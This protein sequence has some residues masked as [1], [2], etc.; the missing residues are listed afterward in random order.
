RSSCNLHCFRVPTPNLLAH[1]VDP[2]IHH[3]TVGV[4]G[5]SDVAVTHH[6]CWTAKGVLT[7]SSDRSGGHQPGC[8]P[9]PS[10]QP[11]GQ[12]I[13]PASGS[14]L[15]QSP[16]PDNKSRSNRHL[17]VQLDR[18]NLCGDQGCLGIEGVFFGQYVK[19]IGHSR[20][21]FGFFWHQRLMCG[22][23][24]LGSLHTPVRSEDIPPLGSLDI[25]PH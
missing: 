25:P 17:H 16:P 20:L 4:R 5:V 11:A 12:T 6:F 9:L 21:S 18:G 3:R 1:L 19:K 2:A 14:H 15:P 22:E 10:S 13:G 23:S 8:L 7:A 24:S